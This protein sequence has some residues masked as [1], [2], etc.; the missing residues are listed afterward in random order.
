MLSVGMLLDIFAEASNDD[1]T[2]TPL[3]TQ[4]DMN[5]FAHGAF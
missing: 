4:E 3:A 5:A 2:Y 1:Y